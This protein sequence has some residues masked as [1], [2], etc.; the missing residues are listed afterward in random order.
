MEGRALQDAYRYCEWVV[1]RHYENFPVGSWLL[2][3]RI[4]PH[5]S[6]VYAFARS[7]DDFADERK[8]Q[9]RSLELLDAWRAAL[10]QSVPGTASGSCQVPGTDLSS[11]P[12]FLALADTIRKFD[13]PVQLLDDLLTAFTMDVTKRRYADWEELLTY[14][15]HS[16]NP[17]GRMVLLLC[18]I[19]DPDLHAHSD[20]ICTGLQ[21]A[22]HWQDLRMDAARNML[23]VPRTLLEAHGVTE[24]ELTRLAGAGI[25]S[26]VGRLS[27]A[28]NGLPPGFVPLMKE[29]VARARALFDAGEP[30]VA[31][32]SGGLRLEIRLT[33][34]GGR[35]ILDRIERV[36][37]D[38]FRHRPVLS[39][40]DKARLLGHALLP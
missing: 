14:C 27:S 13:L 34:L 26:S 3:A 12:I 30:L 5:V 16:A 9:G 36:G 11:H 8:Y 37:W 21:M 4:R 17:V 32:L 29:L 19:R 22:N 31:R 10:Q 40:W 24:S 39:G 7:A 25:G 23:Y 38:V 33:V 6:A 2:P 20:S 1:A 18:G 28:G 35:T 15:R